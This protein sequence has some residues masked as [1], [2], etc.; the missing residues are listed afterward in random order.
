MAAWRV[1]HWVGSKAKKT[2]VQW[3][4]EWEYWLAET[5]A[6]RLVAKLVV[7]MDTKTAMTMAEK[8]AG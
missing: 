5:M 1:G 7:L 4:R 6:E 8:M 2:V 3:V